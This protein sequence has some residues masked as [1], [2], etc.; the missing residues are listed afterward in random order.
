MYDYAKY[1]QYWQQMNHYEQA[2]EIWH[3]Q[4]SIMHF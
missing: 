4:D 3:G 1:L 2:S